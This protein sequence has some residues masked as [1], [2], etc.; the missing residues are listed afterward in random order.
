VKGLENETSTRPVNL[1]I[2]IETQPD[3]QAK[4]KEHIFANAKTD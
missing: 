2:A 3:T 4:S 1:P